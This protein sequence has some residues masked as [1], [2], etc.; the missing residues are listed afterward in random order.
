MSF[1]GQLFHRTRATPADP[2]IRP[3]TADLNQ[4]APRTRRYL[5]GSDYFLPKDQ[6]EEFRLNFQHHALYHAIG[7]HYVAPIDPATRLMLDVGTGTGIWASEMARLF[8]QAEVFGLDVDPACFK[9]D[10]PENC[11]LRAGNILTGLPFPDQVFD[12][13]HQRLLVAAILA[14]NWPGVVRELVRVTRVNGWVE[15]V[16]IDHQMQNPGPACTRLA[17]VIDTVG[18]DMGFDGE[19]MRHLDVLLRQAGLQGVEMQPDRKSV[20]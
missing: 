20:V 9:P 19:V 4:P 12:Y 7:N 8:P 17:S 2:W 15:L 1:F 13:T 11:L 10:V 6:E 5:A 3:T 14:A 16:E 18:R